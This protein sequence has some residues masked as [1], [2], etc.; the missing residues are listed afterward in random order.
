M[1]DILLRKMVVGEVQT[2]CYILGCPKTREGLVI[3]P[4]GNPETI[5]SNVIDMGLTVGAIVNT[6]GHVDH[7]GANR[8]IKE[9]T[10]AELLIHEFD[11]AMLGDPVAN[12]SSMWYMPIVSPPADRLLSEGD[13]VKA[14]NIVLSVVHTPGHTAGGICLVA[15]GLVF[16]G[17]TL[18][19]GS[20]GRTDFP[21]GSV[22][23][24]IH[25]IR[26]KLMGLPRATVI[27]PGHGPNTTIQ[28]EKKSNPYI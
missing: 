12:L 10:G 4:G 20:I 7:I 14:G 16:S 22:E 17:D 25:S 26:T 1:K 18:F 6:H 11:A 23:L 3:D 28:K 2:N 9:A 19:A 5:E 27:L 15:H 21:G 24:L 13:T 8:D